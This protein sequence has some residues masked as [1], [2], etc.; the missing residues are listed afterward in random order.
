M[1]RSPL[2][3][4]LSFFPAF[5]LVLALLSGPSSGATFPMKVADTLQH[6]VTLPATPQRV[7]C[8]AP[9]ITE[10]LVAFGRET[11]L[12]GVTRQD[13]ILNRALRTKNLGSYFRPDMDAIADCSPDLII[14][15]PSQKKV[16]DGYAGGSCALMVMEVHAIEDAFSQ[17]ELFGR[18]FDCET[19]AAAVIQRNRDQMAVVKARLDG[20]PFQNRKRVTRVMVG[21]CLS[22]PGDDS[23]QN[24]MIAAAGGIP[25]QWGRT[26]FA[27]AVTQEEWQAFNPQVVYGCHQNEGAVNDLLHAEGWN[28]VDAVRNGLVTMFPCDLTCQVSTRVGGLIQWLAAVLYLDTFADPQTAVLDDAVLGRRPISL[29]L[30]YVRSAEVITH[31]V[32]DAQYKS[33]VVRFTKPQDILSTFE[34]NLANISAVGNTYIPMAASLGHMACGVAKAQTAIRNNLGFGDGAFATLMTGADM[35]NLAIRKATY[36]DLQVTALVTAG[37]KG[38]AMRM[39]RDSGSYYHPGTINIILLTNRRLTPNAMAR[40][41]I[42]ATEAKTAALLDLD[43]RSSYTPWEHRATGTGTDNVLIVQGD[44]PGEQLTGGHT[45]LGELIASA[46]HAGVTEAIYKQNGLTA[47]RDLFQRLADRKMGLE[48]IV[49]HYS[50]NTDRA[51]LVSRLEDLL[52][53]PYYAGFVESALAISDEYQKGL[54]REQGVFDSMCCSIAAGLSGRTAVRMTEIPTTEALPVVISKAFGA[55]IGGITLSTDERS[56]P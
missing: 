4:R 53:T 55:L 16:I 28:Q 31:R 5:L 40:T 1:L 17:M 48:Q 24:E 30:P 44:G 14:A 38:N 27:I 26:G 21:D 56:E 3:S 43:I 15:A 36:A 29:N 10:M 45:K 49:Q 47:D 9:Y 7:V 46:V 20:I 52:A 19:E 39:S 50:V 6:T 34:G 33:L 51:M 35:A 37:V 18:I 41:I 54:I 12:V 23:F 13:L 2:S 42:T 25:P 8:L 32:A 22:C 11:V